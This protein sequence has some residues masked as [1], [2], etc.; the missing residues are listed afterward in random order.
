MRNLLLH[1]SERD[2]VALALQGDRDDPHAGLE[3]DYVRLQRPADDER[4][5]Q[6]GVPGERQL[7][8]GREDAS[9]RVAALSRRQKEH[10]LGEVHLAGDALHL[11]RAE[12][13]AVDE[14]PE[15]VA[16]QR[17]GGK[18]V[19]HVVRMGLR[20]SFPVRYG[21]DDA[22]LLAHCAPFTTEHSLLLQG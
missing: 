10:R 1:A 13:P 17:L 11:P 18:D 2:A 20:G 16:P 12:R 8:P 7:A 19:Q 15:L 21:R 14:D 6:H 5:P 3:P 4:R 22:M 9:P